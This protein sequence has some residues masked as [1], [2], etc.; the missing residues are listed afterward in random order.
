MSSDQFGYQQ[1]SQFTMD[2]IGGGEDQATVVRIDVIGRT[3]ICE[4]YNRG[5][6]ITRGP[7]KY[8]QWKHVKR[9]PFEKE[10]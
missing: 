5:E 1:N 4:D 10:E 7:S 3:E 2:M 8:N 6:L 9:Q